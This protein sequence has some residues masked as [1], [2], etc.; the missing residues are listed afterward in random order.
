MTLSKI[1]MRSPPFDRDRTNP[2]KLDIM[3][4]V[5]GS[6]T[7]LI[8]PIAIGDVSSWHAHWKP[9]ETESKGNI[10]DINVRSES[11]EEIVSKRRGWFI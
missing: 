9:L 8:K 3:E 2:A 10:R 1:S 4:C 6:V 5:V 7:G 11:D